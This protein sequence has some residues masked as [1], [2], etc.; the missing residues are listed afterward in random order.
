MTPPVDLPRLLETMLSEHQ[1]QLSVRERE[2]FEDMLGQRWAF[3]PR[4]AQWIHSA[5]ERLGLETAP[6]ANLFSNMD[7]EKQE[8]QRAAAA[9]VKLPW[10]K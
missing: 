4:Q 6:S 10:E 8:R 5:A 9:K 2:T 1:E 3:S 7:P